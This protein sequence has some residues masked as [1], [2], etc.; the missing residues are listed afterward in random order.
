MPLLVW[1]EAL[2]VNNELFDRQH[3]KIAEL[4]NDLH[5]GMVAAKNREELDA[6]IDSLIACTRFHFAEE[7]Q[8]MKKHSYPGLKAHKFEHDMLMQQV[9]DLQRQYRAGNTLLTPGVMM[10]LKNWLILHIQRD[11]MKFGAYINDR[12]S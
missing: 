2:S 6:A 5:D 7:E 8:H 12:A 3:R 1:N 10:F 4:I 11:D 9:Q